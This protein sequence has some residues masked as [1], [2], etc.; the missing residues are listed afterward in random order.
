MNYDPNDPLIRKE[1]EN[2]IARNEVG[3]IINRIN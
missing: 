1:I 3:Y 2:R